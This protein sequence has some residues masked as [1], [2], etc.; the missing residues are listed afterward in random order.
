[1]EYNFPTGQFHK[2]DPKG[3]VLQHASQVSSYWPYAHDKFEDDILTEC[4]Q[5]WEEVLQRKY[6]PNMT[7]FKSM[8][9]D[10]QF[11]MIEQRAQEALRVREENRATEAIEAQKRGLLLL[12]ESQRVIQQLEKY[13][14]LLE[15]MRIIPT[16]PSNVREELNCS[17][18][19]PLEETVSLE[20]PR[21]PS[22]QAR[23]SVTIPTHHEIPRTPCETSVP[24]TL[25]YLITIYDDEES[26]E[27]SLI[28]LIPIV[29]VK[30]PWEESTPNLMHRFQTLC[31]ATMR[32]RV[33]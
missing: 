29:E 19:T 18:S 3:L 21:V 20:N 26:S 28:T 15:T 9:M 2:H 8:S 17:D 5:D 12:E 11:K 27:V 23:S 33:P 6:N 30:E 16:N 10:E 14:Q 7:R 22:L 32:P 25:F 1:V 4:A 13:H 31:K 24:N